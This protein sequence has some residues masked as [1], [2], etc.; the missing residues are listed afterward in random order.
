MLE[1]PQNG[2]SVGDVT[3]HGPRFES[4]RAHHLHWKSLAHGIESGGLEYLG[5]THNREG[6]IRSVSVQGQNIWGGDS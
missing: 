2:S 5:V 4:W 3:I 1:W 6:R